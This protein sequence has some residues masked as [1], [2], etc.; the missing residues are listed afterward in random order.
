F[1]ESE[2]SDSQRAGLA[3]MWE[4][5]LSAVSSFDL[6]ANYDKVTFDEDEDD[7]DATSAMLSYRTTLSR[8]SYQLGVGAN[9]I[10]RDTVDDVNGSNI[11]AAIDY[12]GDEGQDW[13][14]SYV[15]QLTDSSLGLSGVELALDN[16][17]ANDSNFAE[18]DIVEIDK[19]DAYWRN[20]ISV[21]S[22][23]SVGAGY[24]KQNYEDTP[25]DQKLAYVQVGYQYTINSRWSAGIDGR[26]ERTKFTDE[27]QE[28]YD[29]TR[30]YLN[31]TYRPIQPLEIRFSVGQEKRDS[32]I[33][34]N[35][36]TDNVALISF[37]YRVY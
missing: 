15:H 32:D 21:T 34:A 20:R 26:F 9:R 30:V 31:A 12:T 27:P 4:R 28:E 23:L 19:F 33:A 14:A 2:S 18:V 5:K 17:S 22:L 1:D 24:Q 10:N 16:F 36:Y 11:L 8:L 35:S 3:V 25:Q 37:R 13:G 6:T 29:T 7:Y